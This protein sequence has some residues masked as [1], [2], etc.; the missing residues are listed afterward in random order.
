M[1]HKSILP[2][3]END[4]QR[5][6]E[7][8]GSKAI[9]N[10]DTTKLNVNPI[11]CDVSLLPHLALAFDTDIVGLDEDEKRILLQNSR[12][13]K[14]HIGSKY[15]VRK[16]AESIFGKSARAIPFYEYGGDAGKY[17]IAVEVPDDKPVTQENLLKTKKVVEDAN[18]A[19]CKFDGF[20]IAMTIRNEA[21]FKIA[22]TSSESVVVLPRRMESI[23]LDIKQQ[24]LLASHTIEIAHIKPQGA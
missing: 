9:E 20:V 22:T 14:L 1:I 21:K 5:A 11:S 6:I 13:I 2:P 10:F 4:T 24:T 19:S 23:V 16:A 17:K 12:G 15:A 7:I 8:V 3:N 18:R